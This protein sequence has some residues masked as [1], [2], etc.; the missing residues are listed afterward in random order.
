MASFTLRKSAGG[1][2]LR[3]TSNDTLRGAPSGTTN[4]QT[5]TA[6]VTTS[7][8]I[9]KQVGKGMTTTATTSASFIKQVGKNLTATTVTLAASV[10]KRDRKS[11]V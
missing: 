1:S 9:A 11:V 5:M 8:S 6:T 3:G 4:P 2:T 7:A 10:V